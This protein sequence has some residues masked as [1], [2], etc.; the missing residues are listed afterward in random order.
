MPRR[1][2]QRRTARSVHAL[3][4]LARQP[5]ILFHVRKFFPFIG[6]FPLS[7]EALRG[8]LFAGISVGLILIPQSMAYAQLAGMPAY[9]GLYA[10]FLPVLVGALWGSSRQLATGPVAMVSLLTGATL[11]QFAAPSSEHY[12]VLAVLLTLMVGFFELAMGVFKLGV[13]VSFLS[14]PVVV[15]FTNAAAIIIAL[16]Q[17]SGLLGVASSR[18]ESFIADTWGVLQQAGDTHLPTLA[19]A[20]AALALMLAMK[21]LRPN[22]PG[23]LV[24]VVVTTVISWAVGFERSGSAPIDAIDDVE[25]RTLAAEAFTAEAREALLETQIGAKSGQIKAAGK[26]QPRERRS[27]LAL[28]YE[29][30]VLR[31]E[32]RDIE[33][34]NRV[35]NRAL[36]KFVFERVATAEGAARL[37]RAGNVPQESVSD[38]HRW[39]I[40]RI[41]DGELRLAGGGQVVGNI[42]R[43]LPSFRLPQISWDTIVM[44][45][46]SAFVITLVGFMEAV[47][48]AKAMATRTRQRIDPNQE[49]IGQGLAN[50]AGSFTQSFPVSGSFSRS[51]VN[52]NAGATSGMASVF[53]WLLV[54]ATLM[55][56]TPL[57]YHLPQ[58]VLAAIILMAVINL[59]D[60]DAMRHAWQAHR[61]DGIAAVA[62]F[63]ATLGFAPHLDAGILAGAGLAIVLYLYRTM[64]PRVALLGRH[65]DGTMR[66][67]RLHGLPTRCD[68]V[69]I[70]YDGSLYF[71]NVP[72]FEDS[73][74][75]Q[76]ANHPSAKFILVVGDGINQ[77]DASGED[78]IRRL[79]ERLRENGVTMAFSGLKQQVLDVMRATGL[80]RDIGEHNLFRTEDMALAALEQSTARQVRA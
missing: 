7:R 54:L 74:L 30:D 2:A 64:T 35:R 23:V 56:L 15:G 59:I 70:R 13:I 8:D 32:V 47:S 41:V 4:P 73:I 48:M 45:L 6:W 39:R 14:H 46:T 75:E 25:I 71:A 80:D 62:T 18:G 12:V 78:V 22:W 24:A 69:V 60:L 5:Q 63:I 43:G 40:Q 1:A 76:A 72:Y 21:K 20:L 44:L 67:A 58:A 51:A 49:L 33:R 9:Y 68:I 61:H 38:G 57:L 29:I 53:T 26:E 19:M 34:E 28:A 65:P 3:E 36:R 31:L 77:L 27:V 52:L 79:V 55:F 10:A 16:S 11:A 66:D 50:I 17:M 37:Y 42:P